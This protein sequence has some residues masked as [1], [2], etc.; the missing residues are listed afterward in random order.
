MKVIALL[1]TRNEA[2]VLPHS[3]ACLSGFCDVIIVNDQNS[4]D[5]TREVC[6]TFPK[7]VLLEQSQS[8]ICGK[9]RWQLWDAARHYDG[10]N[11]L[12]CTDP[13]EL[14]SPSLARQ[15]IAR[16]GDA[17]VPGTAIECL[18]YHPPSIDR[19]RDDTSLY[20]PY[21]KPLAAIDD[22]RMDYD[23]NIGLPLHEY[24]VP[25]GDGTPIVRAQ[26]FPVLHLQWLIAGHNQM[27]QAWYRCIE[28]LTGRKTPVVINEFYKHSLPW[29]NVRTAPIPPAWVQDVT[30]PDMS[31]DETQSWQEREVL[32]LFDEHGAEFFERL[33]IWH[34]PR[35]REEF[36]RRV[37]RRPKADRSY[38][39]TWPE[40]AQRFGR[41]VA[42]AAR[43]RLAP[44]RQ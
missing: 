6:R 28:L 35:L 1:P 17:L 2:W 4:E 3:L 26:N 14:M 18:F 43:R 42:A 41:R 7:V 12:W 44:L 30:F 34:I 23:R 29:G 16:Q 37:G 9:A 19:Y 25:F 21:W 39:P 10:N 8:V 33:E 22:R 36:E 15:F 11:L 27:K 31:I 5:N 40:R 32:A 38:L 24:R 13:D 20:G